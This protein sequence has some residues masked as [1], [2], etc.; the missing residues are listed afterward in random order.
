MSIKL[1]K[2]FDLMGDSMLEQFKNGLRNFEISMSPIVM[3]WKHR[4]NNLVDVWT[5]QGIE[6]SMIRFV[7]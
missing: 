1:L 2:K 7:R 3:S 4:G 6:D 5:Y